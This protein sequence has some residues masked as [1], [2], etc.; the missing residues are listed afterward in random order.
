MRR[1]VV[2][3]SGGVDSA[4][5]A[6]L[7]K[8]AGYDV[9]GITFK[10][11]D[12]FEADDAI[13]VANELNIE[14]HIV[15]YRDIFKEQVIN[16]FIADYRSGITPNPCIMCNKEVKLNFLYQEMKKYNCDYIATGHYA[17]IKEGHLYKSSDEKKDQ[18]YFLC[19]VP[20]NILNS[21]I[22]PLEGLEKTHV[23][24]IAANN[25]LD[26]ANKKDSTDIC[27]ISNTFKEYIK[28]EISSREGNII[29]VNTKK[30]IG[31]HQGLSNYTI[32]QRKGLNIGGTEDRVF[33]VGKDTNKNILYVT[34]G[35][36]E[37]LISTSCKIEKANWLG[38]KRITKCKACFRYHAPCTEVEIEWLS[39][40]EALV[41]YKDGIRAVT[42]GQACVFYHD[43]ECLGGGIIK[44]VYKNEEELWYI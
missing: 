15:D 21:L 40:N 19:E 13:K 12:D 41:N 27:F 35:N 44:N 30:I 26:I 3:L 42:P 23:R 31:K 18:T 22:L 10:F 5:A 33:V 16:K 38:D 28:N 8:E 29:D 36:E 43:D 39:D 7:L 20:K 14:H 6:V 17:K 24:E 25:N 11:T 9:V 34:I 2:G 4:V 32:G 37:N 1:V